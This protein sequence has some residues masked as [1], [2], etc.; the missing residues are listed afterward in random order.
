MLRGK[1]SQGDEITLDARAVVGPDA[2][3]RAVM[4]S[5]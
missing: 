5:P 4:V 3:W 1:F 2:I